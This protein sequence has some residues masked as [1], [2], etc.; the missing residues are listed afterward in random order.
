MTA[1]ALKIRGL[2]VQIDGRFD[3]VKNLSFSVC[4]GETV[5]LV[6]ESGCGKSIS[7]LSILRLLPPVARS[8]A[9]EIYFNGQNLLGL[10]ESEL[11]RIRGNDIAMIFQ[12]PMS[13]LNPLRTIGFQIAEVMMLH[14]GW[15]RAAAWARAAELL[16]IVRIPDVPQVLDGYPH[17]LSGGMR[18]RVMLAMALACKPAVILA[19]EPTTALDVTIQAQITGLLAE[20]QQKFG[21]AI[22]LITHDMGLVAENADRVVVMYAGRKVEE[23]PVQEF[24][25]HPAHPYSRGLL[26][27]L[28]QL[29]AANS[30]GQERLKEIPG[31]VPALGDLPSGCPFFPRCEHSDGICREQFPSYESVGID[32]IAACWHPRAMEENQQ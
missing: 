3:V 25:Q 15:S 16:E 28:P 31:M 32:H 22:V 18:Q 7:A 2:C 29:G 20:M 19:D 23:A 8:V 1:A 30:C 26:N 13:S 11:R 27:S 6:G 17:Q 12:E 10:P 5:C 21:T 14:M 4:P 24:F 9:G